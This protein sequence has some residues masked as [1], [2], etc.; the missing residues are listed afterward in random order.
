MAL[1]ANAWSTP[2][3]SS[4]L[5][6]SSAVVSASL[7]PTGNDP[8]D[9][10]NALQSPACGVAIDG[11]ACESLIVASLDAGRASLG[12]KSYSLPADFTTLAP[13]IQIELLAN[14]D[15]AAYGLSLLTGELG[16]LDGVAAQ[17]AIQGVD[18]NL[19]SGTTLDG[20]TVESVGSNWF[21]STAPANW[22]VVYYDW[23]YNDGYGSNNLACTAPGSPGCWQHRDNILFGG[24]GTTALYFGL[25]M[26]QNESYATSA[27]LLV[28]SADHAAATQVPVLAP[29]S[30]VSSLISSSSPTQGY[31][32]V[33]SDGGI[34]SFGDA[35]FYGST[36]A[37]TLN[38]PI[39]GMASTPD[40]KGYWL[41]A[42]DGGIFSFGDAQFYGSTGNIA[43][44]APIVGM[45]ADPSTGGYW[46][47]ASDGGIFSFN[48][49][50]RGSAGNI[51]LN[52]P[53]VG[54]AVSSL[55]PYAPGES[56]IDLSFPQCSAP[57]QVFTPK[58]IAVIGVTSAPFTNANT[59]LSSQFQSA[60]AAGAV[61]SLYAVLSSPVTTAGSTTETLTGPEAACAATGSTTCQGFNWGYNAAQSAYSYA[62]SQGVSASTWWLDIEVGTASATS[63]TNTGLW[64]CDT[65]VNDQVLAGAIA[66]YSS[67]HVQV[68]I[69]STNLQFSA[70][71]GTYSPGLP[72]WIAGA[73]V[74]TPTSYCTNTAQY[75][76][77]GVPWLVQ[78][79]AGEY[80]GPV[81]LDYAC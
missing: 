26:T 4:V 35:Q 21:G 12:L 2:S 10:A 8:G 65:A 42:S 41:V 30:T 68:G 44:N 67:V 43:L 27:A 69:Y 29:W 63:C 39:V 80:G 58:E 6:K 24:G 40:G 50:F 70:V 22:L 76:G 36:G 7:N 28:V 25:S 32:E 16:G 17:G 53:I 55:D 13:D 79:L 11:S 81:D 23:M 64:T 47:V 31:W 73:P 52:A 75:F 15:R 56:G 19:P 45:A 57:P 74:T 72:I 54:M 71:A 48:A 5:L 20:V 33:A 18:P 59:C 37:M 60:V 77:G 34:F 3:R 38:K 9:I 66:F 78:V 49:P 51:T 62:A 14:Q 61:P 46:L 1:G